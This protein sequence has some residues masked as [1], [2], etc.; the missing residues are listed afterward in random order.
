MGRRV[1]CFRRDE[2]AFG[3]SMESHTG[4]KSVWIKV[5]GAKSE[6]GKEGWR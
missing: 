1:H 2:D 4:V 3:E 6:V 5:G